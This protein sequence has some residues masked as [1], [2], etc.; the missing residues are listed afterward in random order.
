MNKINFIE[1]LVTETDNIKDGI[2]ARKKLNKKLAD[3]LRELR[4]QR[5]CLLRYNCST[6]FI[7]KIARELREELAFSTQIVKNLKAAVK[8]KSELLFELKDKPDESEV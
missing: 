2:N 7:D 1:K 4:K 5:R 6:R 3:D 8:D